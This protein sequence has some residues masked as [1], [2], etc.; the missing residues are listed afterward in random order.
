M[1]NSIA[2]GAFAALTN[3]PSCFGSTPSFV[4]SGK[5]S[6]AFLNVNIKPATKQH[7]SAEHILCK[8]TL[9]TS[10]YSKPLDCSDIYQL[11]FLG[12]NGDDFDFLPNP[13]AASWSIE[14]DWSALS[15]DSAASHAFK[16]RNDQTAF[17]DDFDAAAAMDDAERILAEQNG[18]LNESLS[19]A[20]EWRSSLDADPDASPAAHCDAFIKDESNE[21][22]FV[23]DAVETILNHLD[24]D[25][26]VNLYDT[27]S[28]AAAV[29]VNDEK[30]QDIEM[31]FMVRCGQ[32]PDQFL[33]SEGRALSE[34]TEEEKYSPGFLFQK[35]G[36]GSDGSFQP[37]MTSFFKNAVLKVFQEY[38]VGD[39]NIQS[40]QVMDRKA[41]AKWM[42]NCLSYELT[43]SPNG[44]D[45]AHLAKV[46][47][48]DK[49]INAFLSRYCFNYGSGR[50]TLHDF[51]GL[52][53]ESAWVGYIND[54]RKKNEVIIVDGR[55]HPVPSIDGAVLI[56]DRKNT[57]VFLKDASLSIIWRDLE[58]HG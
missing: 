29:S 35:R 46:G 54:M 15:A 30:D 49:S 2:C 44:R 22:Q 11:N 25:D 7:C 8:S 26:E 48:Y 1:A 12:I 55:F 31:A 19:H 56:K 33:V 18:I 3:A 24:Y 38:S 9:R 34:L 10:L 28:S 14:D 50:L 32:T 27:K 21:D 13:S 42:T 52:Y 4:S 16:P 47:P 45:S 58:A 23:Y 57:D 51:L 37:K 20:N 17:N 53:L 43:T 41:L 40:L 36:N 6:L 5:S 39:E